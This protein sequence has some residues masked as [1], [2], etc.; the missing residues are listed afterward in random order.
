MNRNKGLRQMRRKDPDYKHLYAVWLV[1]IKGFSQR[2]A[3][4]KIGMS[5]STVGRW[6]KRLK[7]HHLKKN[8]RGRIARYKPQMDD[9]AIKQ[10]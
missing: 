6:L 2:A 1:T 9:F 3:G 5:H 7:L 4:R 10:F 8:K